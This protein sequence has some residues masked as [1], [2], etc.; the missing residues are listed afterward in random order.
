MGAN[1]AERACSAQ[2]GPAR[3]YNNLRLPVR[4]AKFQVGNQDRVVV[5]L[6]MNISFEGSG[7]SSAVF[8]TATT[9]HAVGFETKRA[10]GVLLL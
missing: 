7:V 8:S 6:S 10:S 5:P 1:A 4:R 9:F 3:P 2:T